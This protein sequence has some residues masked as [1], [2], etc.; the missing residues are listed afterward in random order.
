ME[1]KKRLISECNYKVI[2]CTRCGRYPQCLRERNERRNSKI[3][4]DMKITLLMMFLIPIIS[5]LAGFNSLAKCC[6]EPPTTPTNEK[7]EIQ[8]TT[9]AVMETTETQSQANEITL[10]EVDKI[11]ET[12]NTTEINLQEES[13]PNKITVEINTEP[14]EVA[15]IS[16]YKSGTEY[17]YIVTDEE[18]IYMA[19]LVYAEAR[20]ECLEGKVAV[21]AVILNR[22]MSDCTWFDR[23]SI[24]DVITQK[25]Q[26]A[27]ISGIT[28]QD[29]ESVPECMEAV[30]YALKGWDPTRKMFENGA[31]FFYA[32]DTISASEAAKREGVPTLIIGNHAF[33]NEFKTD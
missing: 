7:V 15:V 19:K 1:P 11:N 25:W 17:Y 33:H 4:S 14:T 24:Y 21:A 31:C 9:N 5:C 16:A 3:F 20:G 26:F 18:K 8:T 10:R 29:L 23:D 28:E 13:I 12:E 32:P 2:E 22:Y 27:S 30:E 6:E